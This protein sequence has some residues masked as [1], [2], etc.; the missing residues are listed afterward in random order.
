MGVALAKNGLVTPYLASYKE[1][2]QICSQFCEQ[3]DIILIFA[4]VN[5][6]SM[7]VVFNKRY[8][9]ELYQQG[10]SSNKKHRFQPQVVRKYQACINLMIATP[11]LQSLAKYRGLNLKKLIG[12]KDDT[13]S[14]RIDRQYRIE[15]TVQES[16]EPVAT[17]CFI[18]ELSKH[19]K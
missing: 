8:L 7:I 15:F 14:I 19:Y 18:T 5:T 12:D 1:N 10:A 17:I 6:K 16:L 11:D 2:Q 13:F 3:L 9:Q 4:L